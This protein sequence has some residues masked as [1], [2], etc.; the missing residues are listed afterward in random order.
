[1]SD[2]WEKRAAIHAKRTHDDEWVF[3]RFGMVV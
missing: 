3:K 2:A 1:V